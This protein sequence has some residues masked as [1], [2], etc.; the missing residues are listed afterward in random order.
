MNYEAYDEIKDT[1][2]YYGTS[3]S[4]LINELLEY[5]KYQNHINEVDI[6]EDDIRDL[7]EV[8]LKKLGIVLYT[9]MC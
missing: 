4:A 1:I 6:S 9:N 5:V 3:K 2:I 7:N 8:S